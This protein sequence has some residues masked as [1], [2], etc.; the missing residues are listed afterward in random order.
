MRFPW[1]LVRA[2]ELGKANFHLSPPNVIFP[3]AWTD[4]TEAMD[5]ELVNLGSCQTVL[6]LQSMGFSFLIY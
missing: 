5:L 4:I 1:T 6:F 2:G 3:R